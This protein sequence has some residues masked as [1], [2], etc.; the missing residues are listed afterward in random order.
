M[1]KNGIS[2]RDVYE[3]LD[4]RLNEFELMFDRRLVEV[5]SRIERI[6]AR[7]SILEKFESNLMGK[8]TIIWGVSTIAI[9]LVIDYI[10]ERILRI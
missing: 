9:T 4:K 3:L 1:T 8:I 7:T 10:K 2:Y 5:G 6:E